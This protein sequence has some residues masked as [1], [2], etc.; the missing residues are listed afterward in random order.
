[1]S[2]IYI[3]IYIYYIY[4]PN[5]KKVGSWDDTKALEWPYFYGGLTIVLT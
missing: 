4:I 2:I 5:N 1:M 3:Y